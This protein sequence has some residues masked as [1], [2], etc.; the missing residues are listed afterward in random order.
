VLLHGWAGRSRD[1]EDN[2]WA[3]GLAEAG[4]EVL[5]PDL[6]G[7]GDS[8]GVRIPDGTEPGS[9]TAGVMMSDLERLHAKQ[10]AVL[11]YGD[12]SPLA[13]HLAVRAPDFVTRTV[14]VGCD[15]R[16]H[17]PLAL[18][19]AAALRDRRTRIWDQEVAEFVRRARSD[20]RHDPRQLAIWLD[21]LTW[22]ALP[23][24]GDLE[25]PVLLAVGTEDSH[26]AG[27]PRL[28]ARFGDSR[29]VT[30]SGDDRTVLSAPALVAAVLDFLA[31]AERRPAPV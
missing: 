31:E 9:W 12:M 29:L 3:A 20:P 10:V 25:T 27:A 2:G 11:G 16:D 24:L 22:P 14:L 7:H 28:A 4:Y 13:G 18:E 17:D 6:P 21:S 5:V 23:R 30:V 19:A 26:R 15:D 8:A 1:W